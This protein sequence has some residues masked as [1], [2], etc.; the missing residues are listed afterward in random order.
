VFGLGLGRRPSSAGFGVTA[1]PTDG[2]AGHDYYLAE[3]S[4]TL[5]AVSDVVLS[6]GPH[7]DTVARIS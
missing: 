2:V 6:G 3:G 4:A 5:R 7:H 1:L